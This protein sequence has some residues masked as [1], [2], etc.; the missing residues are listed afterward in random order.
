[1]KTSALHVEPSRLMLWAYALPAFPLA[2]MTLPFF[3]I[4]PE[5]YAR[6]LGLPLAAVG[7][8]LLLIRAIDALSDPL[9]GWLCDRTFASSKWGRRRLWVLMTTPFT[10]LAT[11]AVFVPPENASVVYLL[12]TGIALSVSW[13]AFQVP[14]L[15]WGAELSAT[16]HGRTRVAAFR[17]GLTVTGTLIALVIPAVLNAY[18]IIGNR[19]AMQV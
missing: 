8:A 19:T 14:Y 7:T 11:F 15:A 3:V 9:M 17:E 4:V 18:G 10:A 6:E 16:L 2:L 1:M 5:F 13:T 12:I